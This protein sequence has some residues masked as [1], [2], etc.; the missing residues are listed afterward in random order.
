M[1]FVLRMKSQ[2]NDVFSQFGKYIA[3]TYYHDR[4]ERSLQMY[5]YV[6]HKREILL[7][8]LALLST[9]IL[10]LFIGFAGPNVHKVNKI[11][12][13]EIF[14]ESQINSSYTNRLMSSGPFVVTTPSLNTYSQRLCLFLTFHLK[15]EEASEAFHKDIVVKMKL[16]GIDSSNKNISIV[17]D[18]S[19]SYPLYC[20]G[21]QC[22][23]IQVLHLT[24]IAY[25]HYRVNIA[26]DSLESVNN[27]YVIEDIV[28]TFQSINTSFTTLSIWFRFFFLLIAFCVMFWFTHSLYRFPFIDWSLEQKWTALLL[29]LLL[30][31]DNPFY[32]MQFLFG[33]ALPRLM[34]IVFQSSLM[35]AL[36]LFW[37]CFFHGIRQNNRSLSRF[38]A[39]KL[40]LMFLLWFVMVY[41][42]SGSVTNQLENPIFDETKHFQN[43]TFLQFT[44]VL[45]YL[46]LILYFIYLILLMMSA[47]TELRSMPYFDIRLKLQ[48]FLLIFVVTISLLTIALSSSSSAIST[49]PF[50]Q[51]L[52]FSYY[53]GS[54][55][56]FLSIFSIANLYVCICAYYYRPSLNQLTD[57]RVVR[58]NPTLSMINDSDEDVIYGSDTEEPLQPPKLIE[59]KNDDEESD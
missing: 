48:A 40:S 58:D 9:Y 59:T 10:L 55:A 19:L 57:C 39:P 30:V 15:N 4:C 50:L 14:T 34:E 20:G 18:S 43:S 52:P 1:S 12:A 13:T 51:M 47:F 6:M 33:S 56:A 41:V 38:Y 7:S 53:Y 3:P 54:S 46:L 37:L 28:F 11:S 42:M 5:L 2:L 21:R 27:K 22:E 49:I 29:V 44:N 23:P 45:F 32:S 17:S 24:Y 31:T 26:F 8:L 16:D 35:C 25:T 36:M